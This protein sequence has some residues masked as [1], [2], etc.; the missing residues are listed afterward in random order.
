MRRTTCE[1]LA[2]IKERAGSASK[3]S[4]DLANIDDVAHSKAELDELALGRGACWERFETWAAGAV[5]PPSADTLLKY[6]AYLDGAACGP[7]VLASVPRHRPL[8]LKTSADRPAQLR[9]ADFLRH[10][11]SRD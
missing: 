8:D 11:G 9:A 7:C 10:R 5:Y 1:W 4:I 3:V 6:Y 2:A